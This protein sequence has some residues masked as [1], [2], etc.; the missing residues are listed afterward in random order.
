MTPTELGYS[1]GRR[2]WAIGAAQV[3]GVLKLTFCGLDSN[4]VVQYVK[5][6]V[7]SSGVLVTTIVP[8]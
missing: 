6:M 1:A 2:L 7:S 8:H 3:D 4:D 5:A